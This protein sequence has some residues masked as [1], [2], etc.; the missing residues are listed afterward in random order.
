MVGHEPLECILDL[1]P[2]RRVVRRGGLRSID[3][4]A[5]AALQTLDV[6][7][8]K[9]RRIHRIA[10]AI[11]DEQRLVQQIAGKQI[12]VGFCRLVREDED[13]AVQRQEARERR[14]VAHRRV[15]DAGSTIGHAR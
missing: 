9:A 2:P 1:G 14:G 6:R 7:I 12:A 3:E 10:P 13:E 15:V 8:D 5:A 4:L 11:D